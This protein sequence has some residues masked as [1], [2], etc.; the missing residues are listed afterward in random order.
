MRWLV[1]L[2]VC[3]VPVWA[4]SA[5][6]NG[7]QTIRR[8][9]T[10][11][12]DRMVV[13]AEAL[14]ATGQAALKADAEQTLRALGPMVKYTASRLPVS[15][16]GHTAD[17]GSAADDQTLSERRA[18]AVEEWLSANGFVPRGKAGIAGYARKKPPSHTSRVEV[19]VY[20]C[21][22]ARALF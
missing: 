16:E 6:L 14:F 4:E 11:C 5:G 17:S 1:G 8:Q 22:T 13:P 18:R 21:T 10:K 7:P 9:D 3:A 12:E 19:V 20:H 15:I 2:V